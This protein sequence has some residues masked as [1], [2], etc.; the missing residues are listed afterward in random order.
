MGAKDMGRQW[1]LSTAVAALAAAV[2]LGGCAG[3]GTAKDAETKTV[4]AGPV[5][6]LSRAQTLHREA[7]TLID[8][9]KFSEAEPLLRQALDADVTYGPAHNSMGVVN[10]REGKLYQ[11]AWEFQYAT[12]LMPNQP[13]PRSN[14]GLVLEA[15]GRADDA[16]AEYQKAL[17]LQP[18]NPELIGNLARA[19]VRRGDRTQ[20]VRGLLEQVVM[21][22]TRREWVQWAGETLVRMPKGAEYTL[23]APGMR[24]Q[25]QAG[26]T[27]S[28]FTPPPL[29]TLPQELPQPPANQ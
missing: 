23:P 28:N 17:A 19:L 26:P 4:Q 20:E 7:L 15:V 24:E 5:R 9:Q 21:K 25:L 16:V 12:R 2:A 22:D 10:L 6:D 11:A 27:P 29:P 18:D 14:L 13:E 8:E 3:K 1:V